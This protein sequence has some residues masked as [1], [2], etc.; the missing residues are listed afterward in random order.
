MPNDPRRTAPFNDGVPRRADR[1]TSLSPQR[2]R[3]YSPIISGGLV[4]RPDRY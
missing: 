2:N 1:A 3:Q 4:M